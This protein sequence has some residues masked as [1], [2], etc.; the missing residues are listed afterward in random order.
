M[1]EIVPDEP[2]QH[3]PIRERARADAEKRISAWPRPRSAPRRRK[4]T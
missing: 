4:S 2:D 3:E 1:P